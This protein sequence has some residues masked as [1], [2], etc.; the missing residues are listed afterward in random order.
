MTPDF[1]TSLQTW[2]DWLLTRHPEEID[3]G[4]ERVSSVADA[5]GLTSQLPT[6]VTVAGTNGKGSS[7]A[8]LDAIYRAAG[9]RTGRFTSPH[10][11]RFNERIQLS[12]QDVDDQ[13]LV[14]AFCAI[15]AA[16]GD[17]KLT[18]FECATLAALWVFSQT[19]LDVV[20]LEVGLGGRLDAVNLVDADASLITAI[21]VDHQEWLGADRVQIAV[22]K[23]GIMRSGKPSVCSDPTVPES[24]LGYAR[25]HQVPLQWLGRDFHYEENDQAWSFCQGSV[26]RDD[27]PFPALNGRFQRQNAAGVLA[28]IE[29][30]QSVLPV[31]EVAIR[32]G[33]QQV[34]HLGR[35]QHLHRFGQDWWLD[36]AHNPQ[37]A[38]ALGTF[39]GQMA[40]SE[41]FTRPGYF[42]V[43]I[44][45]VLA[46]KEVLPMVQ[47]L[48]PYVSCWALADLGVP[49]ALPLMDLEAVLWQAGV[50]PENIVKYA[51]ISEAVQ[52]YAES[53]E[54]ARLRLLVW[55]SFYTVSQALARFEND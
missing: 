1:N 3:L 34:S 37:S 10:L 21:D 40:A 30:L 32:Q 52:A 18:F 38:Q 43:A 23:A 4:L 24:L 29:A 11:L 5:L 48:A 8:M 28:V 26:Q 27:L 2:L 36:V 12:G 47:A 20:L 44:F 54:S 6:V 22:E 7:V 9:Y 55:G 42:D 15:E 51:S 39:V 17:I 35:L 49:R 25:Q 19:P 14:A 16:R 46:D 31:S 50:A 41:A 45:S 13:S 33:L 53:V